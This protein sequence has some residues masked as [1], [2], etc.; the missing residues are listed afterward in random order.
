NVQSGSESAAFL[1]RDVPPGDY[2][3]YIDSKATNPINE[4]VSVSITR[5]RVIGLDT[6]CSPGL[7][8]ERCETGATCLLNP[9]QKLASCANFTIPDTRLFGVDDGGFVFEIN[10]ANGTVITQW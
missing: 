10:P 3:L 9:G 6:Q 2:F 8:T 5:T 1:A 7:A 4:Q